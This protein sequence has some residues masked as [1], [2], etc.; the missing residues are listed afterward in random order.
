MQVRLYIIKVYKRVGD[1]M[2]LST[3]YII[4]EDHIMI[5]GYNTQLPSREAKMTG[6]PVSLESVM[7]EF[8]FITT[9]INAGY[10]S[11]KDPA[12]QKRIR[13]LQHDITH[14]QNAYQVLKQSR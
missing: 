5:N 10:L 6:Q 11:A 14:L 3:N 9:S 12:V 1:S 13:E 4:K 8:T 2:L 7:N